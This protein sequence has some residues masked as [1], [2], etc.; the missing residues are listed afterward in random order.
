MKIPKYAVV[1]VHGISDKKGDQQKN[2]SKALAEKVLPD[3]SL[4][5]KYWH[6]AVWEPVNNALDD[7]IQDVVLQL[8]NTYDK[9]SYWRDA[10]LAK[11]KSKL[12]KAWV[13]LWWCGC[14]VVERLL[15]NK[16]TRALDLV[17]DLPMYL[18]SKRS[19]MAISTLSLIA[20]LLYFYCTGGLPFTIPKL[21]K[22][23][24][25]TGALVS[26]RRQNRLFNFYVAPLRV[27]STPTFLTEPKLK[28][29]E[30]TEMCTFAY[31]TFCRFQRNYIVFW[32]FYIRTGGLP[33]TP[34][35]A[36]P[37]E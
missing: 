5:E 22:H 11:A 9:T 14:W 25:T 32:Y 36:M 17:L 8:V 29:A 28:S 23:E 26:A 12:R 13:W 33:F 21:K 1:V 20:I 37:V 10:E 30:T 7:K 16:I 3:Q 19:K 31:V 4:R 24:K 35:A 6:E 18:V 2:F 34:C 27:G 15:A